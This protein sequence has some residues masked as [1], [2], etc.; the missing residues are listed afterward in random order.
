MSAYRHRQDYPLE[1]PGRELDMVDDY[2]AY[3]RLDRDGDD[4]RSECLRNY[5]DSQLATWYLGRDKRL[6]VVCGIF[7]GPAVFCRV[8][9]FPAAY[10]HE[11]DRRLREHGSEQSGRDRSR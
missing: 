5:G 2:R 1:G 4:I 11:Q 10:R 9:R 3:Q 6:S 7:R 8:K